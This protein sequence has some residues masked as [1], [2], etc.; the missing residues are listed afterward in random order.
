MLPPAVKE[1]LEIVEYQ[2]VNLKLNYNLQYCVGPLLPSIQFK[3]NKMYRN[4]KLLFNALKT[5]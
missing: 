3:F 1:K 5:N 4:M 2:T